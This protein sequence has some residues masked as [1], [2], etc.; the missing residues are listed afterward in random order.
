MTQIFTKTI[1]SIAFEHW[2]LRFSFL[3]ERIDLQKF[4]V[5]LLFSDF[6]IRKR[7]ETLEEKHIAFRKKI[8]FLGLKMEPK[9]KKS[10]EEETLV[11]ET[12][13]KPIRS[14]KTNE[15]KRGNGAREKKGS[16]PQN[17]LIN[18]E[19][20]IYSLCLSGELMRVNKTTISN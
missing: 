16:E 4:F 13:W 14:K 11:D 2:H 20:C 18:Y 6:R 5:D 10:T 9:K 12:G 15:R 1:Y 19:I 8:T 7:K 17:D 3:N